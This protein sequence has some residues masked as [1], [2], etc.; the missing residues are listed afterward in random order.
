MSSSP[1]PANT[2]DGVRECINALASSLLSPSPRYK[3][4]AFA[5]AAS[6]V[7]PEPEPMKMLF[8]IWYSELAAKLH[9]AGT[10]P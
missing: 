8:I 10:S 7:A 2:T 1:L 4:S 5:P 9:G 3:V 6:L